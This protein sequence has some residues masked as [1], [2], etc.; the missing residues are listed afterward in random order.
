MAFLLTGL[1]YFGM[2]VNTIKPS[3]DAQAKSDNLKK[4]VKQAQDLNKATKAQ[5]DQI[6][7]DITKL[8]ADLQLEITAS[9]N[10]YIKLQA[11]LTSAQDNFVESYRTLQE[12]G[13][14][15]IIVTFLLLL[16]KEFDLLN[17]VGTL[18]LMPW[19]LFTGGTSTQSQNQIQ[20]NSQPLV[21]NVA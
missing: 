4:Q 16:L 9:L 20:L 2:L 14:V 6:A 18:I 21:S 19:K 3:I 5:F 8:S 7:G 13:I 11:Q 10:N 17:D 15:I 12:A 1:M